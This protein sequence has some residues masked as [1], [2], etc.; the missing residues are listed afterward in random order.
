MLEPAL[1][2]SLLT[3]WT[4][5]LSTFT[6]NTELHGVVRTVRMVEGRDAIQRDVVGACHPPEVQQSQ[7][8][9]SAPRS[10][11]CQA[12]IQFRQ[13]DWDGLRAY[14]RRRTTFIG[15]FSL[16]ALAHSLVNK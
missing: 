13:L 16:M 1:L 12:Q 15:S 2:T 9:D 14:L 3:V 5:G 11:H 10:G 4:V 6:D 8:E 7:V